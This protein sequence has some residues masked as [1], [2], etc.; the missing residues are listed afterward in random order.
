MKKIVVLFLVLATFF[1]FANIYYGN[2]H[3]HT[4]YSDGKLLPEDAYNYAKSYVDVQAVTDHAYYFTQLIDGKT[5][6]FLTKK[7]AENATIEGK[8][9]ALQGFEWT[10]GIGHIN[11]YESL[12]WVDRN[13]VPSAEDFYKWII[14]HKK[15]GQFNH[16]IKIFGNFND[17]EYYPE[18]DKY[19]NLIEVGNG[20]WKQG[21]VISN[22]M[23]KNYNLAL[24]KGWHLG[25]TVGQDNHKANWGSANEGRTGIISNTLTYEDVMGALW[26]RHTFGTEDKNVKVSFSYKNYIMGDIVESPDEAILHFKYKDDDILTYFAIVSQSGTI[27]S[28][29]PNL[30]DYATDVKIKIPDGYEWYYVYVKQSD[31]DEIVTAPIFF[32]KSSDV[33]VNNCNYFNGKLSFDIY[34]IIPKEKDVHLGIK[35]NNKLLYSEDVLL[36]AYEN[37]HKILD[38]ELSSGSNKVEF[39]VDGI[40]VQSLKVFIKSY[41]KT[42]VIDTLHENDHLDYLKKFA[43]IL[44]RNGYKVLYPK[45]FL[46]NLENVDILI[47][48]TPKIDGFDF[49]KDLLSPELKALKEFKGKIILIKGSD[50]NYFEIYRKLLNATV[51]NLEDL[52]KY[53]GVFSNVSKRVLIDI[54]HGNDY[55]KEKLTKFE[56]FLKEK[57]FEVE[58]IQKINKSG[59]ILIIQNGKS[60]TQDEIYNI[61]IFI[62]NGGKVIITSKSDF[63]NGGNTG[64][65]NEILEYLGSSI[66]FNDDQVLDDVNNYGAK[67]KILVN[68]VRFYS[69]CSLIVG[70]NAIVLISSDTAYNEDSDGNGD[71]KVVKKIVLAAKEVIGNGEVIVLGKSIFSDY[72]FEYDKVFIENILSN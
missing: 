64:T 65:L 53:F 9:I 17:F 36:N 38:L 27:V 1:S 26:S 8:F 40:F 30:N 7:A 45:R 18:A 33:Y 15:L 62:Q 71:A 43:E 5:K 20:N 16:P 46:N 14:K 19:M 13:N 10:S 63:R 12:E 37:R 68:G 35:V 41:K 57:G 72:D 51:M 3:A 31:G 47:I 58:Y 60:Y 44:R 42:V 70:Y 23:L 59:D 56:S 39:Y 52:D 50:E 2:L 11:V 34:N 22:E 21:D 67:Y 48:S 24:N 66:R 54:G 32:Q 25:A 69:P 28:A 55:G 61:K 49:S 6:P 29:F 4:S